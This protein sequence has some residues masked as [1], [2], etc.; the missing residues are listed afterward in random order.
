MT[1]PPRPMG[2]F[3]PGPAPVVR[4]TS[5]VAP[6]APVPPTAARPSFVPVKPEEAKSGGWATFLHVIMG[7]NL[8]LIGLNLVVGLFVGLVIMFAPD[9]ALAEEFRDLIGIGLPSWGG[10]AFAFVSMGLVPV[11]WLLGTRV[12][13]WKGT[14]EFLRLDLEWRWVWRG[15]ALL[16]V[17]LAAYA[18]LIGVSVLFPEEEEPEG[19]AEA[20]EKLSWP[21]IL[22]VALTAGITEE[23]L[24][25]GVLFRWVGWWGQGLLFAA[26]HVAAGNPWQIGFTL[27]VGLAF[28]WLRLRGWSLVSLMIAH[29][30]YD[31]VALAVLKIA[32]AASA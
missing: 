29:V 18:A 22:A 6:S 25:R 10:V 31:V 28:G 12:E 16:G 26:A 15:F 19:F 4:R 23:I 32:G 27:A 14:V 1:I 7:L 5:V 9:S 2:T 20:V 21:L 30:L 13:P 17:L 24:F 11:V 8:A 3:R